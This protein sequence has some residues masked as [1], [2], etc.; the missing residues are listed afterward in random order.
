[1]C[2]AK[3]SYRDKSGSAANPLPPTRS[4]CDVGVPVSEPTIN[5]QYKC[6]RFKCE[7]FSRLKERGS[8]VFAKVVS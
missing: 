1:M 7:R 4:E 3:K 8:E 5:T 2:F 6:K